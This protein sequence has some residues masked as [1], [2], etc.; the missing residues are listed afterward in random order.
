MSYLYDQY[1]TNHIPNRNSG[2]VLAIL[3]FIFE[4]SL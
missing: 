1:L 3:L 2:E 4:R